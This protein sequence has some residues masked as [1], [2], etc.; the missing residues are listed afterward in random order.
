MS[1]IRYLERDKNK[2]IYPE[3]VFCKD[4]ISASN[5]VGDVTGNLVGNVTGN[6]VGNVT[7]DVTSD[8]INV[9]VINAKANSYI[10]MNDDV[11]FAGGCLKLTTVA[12]QE[13]IFNALN[14]FHIQSNGDAVLFIQAD[15]DGGANDNAFIVST[16]DSGTKASQIALLDTGL[17]RFSAGNSSVSTAGGYE[18]WT[19]LVSIN[20]GGDGRPG[21][22]SGHR[23]MHMD[24][25]NIILDRPPMFNSVPQNDTEDK[26]LV[27]NNG[28]N[29]VEFRDSATILGAKDTATQLTSITTDVTIDSP[30][31]TITTVNAVIA[32][33]DTEGFDVLNST[34]TST[35]IVIANIVD[36][37][38]VYVTQGL[39][40]LNIQNITNGQFSVRI[41]NAGSNG[42][43][44]VLK[45]N[46]ISY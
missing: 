14:C 31:G 35:S 8:T 15:R 45:I 41:T 6:L 9:D 33:G 43:D 38:G 37:S 21:F 32:A 26:I 23:L 1:L 28:T 12:G 29:A 3:N 34:I 5:I 42:T 17:T 27:L 36:Y 7:G 10:K 20:S 24:T 18:F 40:G 2:N 30:A 25:N 16:I 4:T 13:G 46:F 19:Q 22:T 44:G 11:S 39:P